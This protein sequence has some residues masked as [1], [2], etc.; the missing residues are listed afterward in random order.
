MSV[1]LVLLVALVLGVVWPRPP[2]W[3]VALL[4]AVLFI[5]LV[6]LAYSG[7]KLL[8]RARSLARDLQSCQERARVLQVERPMIG[9]VGRELRVTLD[10]I[11]DALITTDREGLIVEINPQAAILTGQSREEAVG[12]PVDR[13][14]RLF[15]PRTGTPLDSPVKRSLAT[16]LATK[17]SSA[18]LEQRDGHCLIVADSCAP[19]RG[20]GGET[21]G[22]VV[23]FRDITEDTRLREQA[24]EQERTFRTLFEVTPFPMALQR[25]EDGAYQMVNP[26]FERVANEPAW[27]LL[28]RPSLE[29]DAGNGLFPFAVIREQL[30]E[31]GS[32]R[33]FPV[34]RKMASGLERH[35]L[36]ASRILEFRGERCALTVVVDVTDYRQLQESLAHAQ[37]L[38]AVGQ[39][40][41]GVAHDFNNMLG[42]ILGLAEF[43]RDTELSRERQ[44]RQLD[45]IVAACRR[46]GELSSKLLAFARRGKV[47]STPVDVHDTLENVVALLRRT[48][49]KGIAI[50]VHAGAGGAEVIGDGSMLM[51]ALLNLGINAAHAM[52]EGGLI[53]MGTRNVLLG[54]A[55]CE[56]S[57]F[58]LQPGPFLLVEV[59]DTGTGI[60]PGHLARIFD[61]YFTTKPAGQG[62][63]L[64]LAAVYGTVKQHHGAIEVASELGRGSLF[65]LYLPCATV[66][67]RTQRPAEEPVR[68]RGT[69]LLVDDEE[70]IRGAATAILEG[71]GYRVLVARNGEEALAVHAEA[72]REIRMV[73]LDMIMPRMAGRECFQR[74]RE[75]DPD[76]P[77]LLASGF[78]QPDDLSS[79]L[80][81]GAC[82]FLRKP[83]NTLEL[84]RAV[85]ASLL[86]GG[87]RMEVLP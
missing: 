17:R 10:A 31:K 9:E 40:A 19:I 23:I 74:L 32:L 82:A 49:D 65:R 6:W 25:L 54:E 37:R 66:Q 81:S 84:S 14:F 29:P 62:T 83:Y 5:Q 33:E 69:L 20:T 55:Y 60:A 24:L 73:I 67:G 44:V 30:L 51:N 15:D 13:V 75:S 52:P 8:G 72:R 71:L 42:G 86:A 59:E 70:I 7:L 64:G 16:G 85:A 57:P 61:P 77:V 56:A 63:G 36:V 4:V 48:L 21:V 11:G 34:S 39:L 68:G 22:A 26:A 28:G 12:S 76:L 87:K 3:A 80:A 53:R 79:L 46:A 43:I 45:K 27:E 78:S 2:Q 18:R 35:G 50:Q 38:D 58:D 1:P 47:E 41:G